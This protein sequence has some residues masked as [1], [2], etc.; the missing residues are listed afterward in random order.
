MSR[1][2]ILAVALLTLAPLSLEGQ[3]QRAGERIDAARARAAQAG[4]PVELLESRISEG[5][6]KGVS[7]ERIAAAV[8]RRA[9][10]LAKSQEAISRSGRQVGVDGLSAGADAAEAGV[11][12]DALRAVI[13]AARA[14]EEPIALAVLG[15]L[16]RQGQPVGNALERV[17]Q[18][19][20]RRDGSLATLPEQAQADR[21]RRGAPETA[22]RPAGVGGGRPE[23]AGQGAGG[24]R[25]GPP[26][27]IPAAGGRPGAGGPAAGGGGG[28]RPAGTPGRGRPGG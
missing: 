1:T 28:G 22:G 4:I 25:G 11:D 5:R 2:T 15:E 20:A 12:A 7:E 18:A 8:E 19:L 23:G 27:A 6:A 13:Q 14:G 10:G 21:G 9:A 16:V 24:A 3:A 17:T 26:A